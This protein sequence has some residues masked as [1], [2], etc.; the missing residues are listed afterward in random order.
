MIGGNAELVQ[1]AD[2]DKAGRDR[3]ARLQLLGTRPQGRDGLDH[4]KAG[5]H[6]PLRIVFTRPR[7]SEIDHNL[8]A[9]KFADEA[10]VLGDN[11]PDAVLIG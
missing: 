11:G 10:A 4:G 5:A 9:Q 1:I 8:V 3:N 7:I 2:D 6:R